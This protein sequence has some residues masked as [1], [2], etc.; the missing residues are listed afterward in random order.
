MQMNNGIKSLIVVSALEACAQPVENRPT[1]VHIEPLAAQEPKEP[2]PA[3]PA[4]PSLK[5]CEQAQTMVESTLEVNNRIATYLRDQDQFAVSLCM[6]NMAIKDCVT[7]TKHRIKILENLKGGIEACKTQPTPACNT[8]ISNGNNSGP[9][10]SYNVNTW[11]QHIQ[12]C[13]EI[14]KEA[15]KDKKKPL[16]NH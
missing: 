1:M 3:T 15:Q 11:K 4:L 12:K 10:S 5:D 14:A 7:N 6:G 16:L 9:L 8:I 13:L 2:K